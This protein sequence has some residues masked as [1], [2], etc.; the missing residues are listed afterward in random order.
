[1]ELPKE[2]IAPVRKWPRIFYVYG[3]PK[4]GKTTILSQLENNLI[5]ECDE[6]GADFI[7]ALRIQ[8]N[9]LDE[10]TQVTQKIVAAKKPYKYVSLDTSTKLEEWAEGEATR[11]YKSTTIGKTFTGG[12]VLELPQGAGYYWLRMAFQKYINMLVACA[13][14]VIIT[15][16]IKDK[17]LG[18]KK[19]N[20]VQATDIDHTG[21]I[22]R[23]ICAGADAIGYLFRTTQQGATANAP[24]T[25]KL[26]ISFKTTDVVNCGTRCPYLTGQ[27]FD[28]DWNKIYPKETVV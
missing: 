20:D 21:Q 14:H 22:K 5:I 27:E 10:Y 8:V 28:F 13:D 2:P 17:W 24:V 12:S 26:K 4:I 19:D 9:N 11:M 18:T 25:Q 6:G 3:P 1:M 23:M 16:H 15:G 7:T